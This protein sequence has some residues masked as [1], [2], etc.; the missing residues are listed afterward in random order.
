MY[1]NS[2]CKALTIKLLEKNKRNF[3]DLGLSNNFLDRTPKHN[4]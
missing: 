3:C 2:K 4:Q 1:F